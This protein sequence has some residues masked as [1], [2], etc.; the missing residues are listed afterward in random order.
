MRYLQVHLF[1]G[2]LLMAG[3]VAQVTDTGTIAF[4]AMTPSTPGT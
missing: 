1:G 3:I 4:T 2:V